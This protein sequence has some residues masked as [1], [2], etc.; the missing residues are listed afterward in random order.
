MPSTPSPPARSAHLPP[1]VGMRAATRH[2]AVDARMVRHSGIG[3]YLRELLPRL[4]DAQPDWRFSLLGDPAALAELDLPGNADVG[5][6]RCDAPL[7]SIRE[8]VAVARS[9]PAGTTLFWAP[10]YVIPLPWRGPLLV[11]VHDLFH[12]AMPALVGGP[13]RRLFAR[14]MFAA[15]RRRATRIVFDSSFSRREFARLVGPP[16]A[17]DVVHLGVAPSW[18]ALRRAPGT[19]RPYLLYVGNVKPHKNVAM[20][21]RAFLSLADRVPHRLVIAGRIDG[22][23]TADHEVA[24]LAAREPDRVELAG[25]VSDDALRGWVAG[26]DALALP[27][28]YEGFGLPPL[29]AMAVGVPCLVSTAGSLPEV[30]GDAALYCDPHREDDVAARVLEL[31]TDEALRARLRACGPEHSAQFTWERCAAATAAAIDAAVAA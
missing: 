28:L 18:R 3:T 10:H 15:V 12:L 14:G 11:T 6:V 21:V 26:A 20:L 19:G 24:R 8:Q 27:S 22:L 13:A 23:K 31:L 16:R 29:E 7:Y 5:I 30:C 4:V 1:V 2:V 17:A 9:V 25:E